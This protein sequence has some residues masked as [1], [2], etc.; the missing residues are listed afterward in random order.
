[1]TR[2]ARSCSSAAPA[3]RDP[4]ARADAHARSRRGAGAGRAATRRWSPRPRSSTARTLGYP[5][6]GALAE[7]TGADE[8]ARRRGR[9]AARRSTCRR[10]VQVF[11][12]DRRARA[13]ARATRSTL[14]RGW[15]TRA[16][17]A[18]PAGRAVGRLR[19]VVD[20]TAASDGRAAGRVDAARSASVGGPRRRRSLPC[21]PWR[22][23]RSGSSA[24][25]CSSGRRPRSPTSTA[26]SSKLVDAMYETMYEAPGVGLAAPQ[27]GVQKRFFVYDVPDE[28]GPHVLLNPQVVETDGRVALRGGLPLAARP[29]VR[30]RAPEARHREGPRP[31]RQR[32]RDRGR[33]AARPGASCTR[34]TTSTA[35]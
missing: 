34:S 28:T 12:P 3:P 9:R 26:P 32:G 7:L 24:T 4:A 30:D 35:C 15:P 11:G 27:V 20:P 10:R 8:R 2:A 14:G 23:T 29:R 18:V 33:R 5:P 21:P 16:R 22:L 31:R 13:C 25:R 1:M 6:F 17:A 19:A